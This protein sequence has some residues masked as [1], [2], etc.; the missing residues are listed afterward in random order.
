[1]VRLDW[2]FIMGGLMFVSIVNWREMNWW[3]FA[4]AFWWIDIVGT[5]PGMYYHGKN[6]HAPAGEDVPKWTI[7][8][9]NVCHSF[10]TVVSITCIW[11]L[12]SG[13]QW[14][15]LAMPMHVAAD[16][17]VFGNIYK[18]FYIKF[19]PKPVTAFTKFISDF[20]SSK[21]HQHTYHRNAPSSDKV[22]NN[23]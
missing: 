19:D 2:L 18:N 1:M 3:I 11:Y 16:R 15:M 8:A 12:Y 6:K 13:W 23:V 7:I 22:G 5:A 9:Y 20:S 10:V 17:C 14:E 21:N 4:F